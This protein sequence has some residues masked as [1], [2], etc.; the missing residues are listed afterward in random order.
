MKT[1]I[2]CETVAQPAATY[3][4]AVRAGNSVYVSG[5]GP[6]DPGTGQICGVTI[7]D[8]TELTLRNLQEILNAAGA[9]LADVVKVNAHLS[10]IRDFDAFDGIY[11]RFFEEPFPARTTVSSRLKGILVEIDAVAYIG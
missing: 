7:E 11:K 8:Q 5:Q 1:E 9:S 4:H 3:S 2:I 6:Q 10:D